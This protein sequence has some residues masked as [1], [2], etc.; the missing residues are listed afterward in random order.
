MNYSGEM[1]KKVYEILDADDNLF[2]VV[3]KGK[4]E[5]HVQSVLEFLDKIMGEQ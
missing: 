2:Y 4:H 5:Y 3:H 1:L